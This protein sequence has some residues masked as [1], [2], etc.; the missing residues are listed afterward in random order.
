MLAASLLLA[1][2]IAFPG[3]RNSPAAETPPQAPHIVNIINFVRNIEPRPVGITDEDLFFATQQEAKLLQKH[4]LKG[5]FL[6]Q[7][8]ALINPKYQRLMKEELTDGS[9]VGGWWEI[10]QPH[11]EAAGIGW[12]GAYPWDWHANVGFATGYTPAER[13]KLVDVYMAKF[14]EIFGHYPTA[15]GSWFIDAHT[16]RYMSEKYGVIASCNCRDQVGTDGYTLWG[17]YWN[18]AYYPSKKNAYM[19]AQTPGEQIDIPVFR[20]LG[21]DPINQYDSHIGSPAQGV[22]TLEPVYG[23]GGGNPQW[24]DWFFSQLTDNPCLAFQYTQVGQENSFTWSRIGDGL[25]YQVALVDSLQRAG[26]VTVQT[27]SESGKWFRER[28]PMTPATCIMGLEDI[29]PEDRKSVWYESRFYRGNLMWEDSTLRFRDIHLFD[30]RMAS[31]YLT[32]PGTSEL[33]FYETLPVVDGFNWSTAENVAG[34]RLMV[35]DAQGRLSAVAVGDPAVRESASGELTVV[36]PILEGDSCRIVF[37]EEA[38][39]IALPASGSYRLAFSAAQG[40][41]LPFTGMS[42]NRIAA[43]RKGLDYRVECTTGT[44]DDTQAG[45]PFCLSPDADGRIELNMSQR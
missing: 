18:Q 34:L 36:T 40:K 44:L 7:Y 14:K 28:F 41:A 19:P 5:T 24:V 29:R 17:G 20:M 37:G 9:E 45:Y 42:G 27:L 15:V 23:G 39:R 6:L 16:L 32:E 25:T 4:D 21:S 8:D 3:C 12:R 13:E 31:D 26:K 38:I 35:A 33:C 22:E 11:A 10:T 43:S 30:E 1:G 2:V